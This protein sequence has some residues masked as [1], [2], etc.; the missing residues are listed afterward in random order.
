MAVHRH[1]ENLSALLAVPCGYRLDARNVSVGIQRHLHGTRLAALD[2]E[3][4]HAHLR[5]P[6]TGNGVLIRIR[7]GIVGKGVHL[8]PCPLVEREGELPHLTLIITNPAEL[9][10]VGRERHA[11]RRR[12]L[13]FVH[14]VGYAVDDLIALAISRYLYFS[15]VV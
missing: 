14:P 11:L 13:L 2:V 1:D 12:E 4:H 9:L 5:V 10:R 8:R 15:I 6:F 7:P 3:A